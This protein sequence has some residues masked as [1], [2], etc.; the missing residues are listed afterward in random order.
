MKL[1][2]TTRW[3]AALGLVGGMSFTVPAMADEALEPGTDATE[4]TAVETTALELG[5]V[6]TLD[7]EEPTNPVEPVDPEPEP[8][9]EPEPDPTNPVDPEPEPSP[10]PTRPVAP[11]EPSEPVVPGPVT[12]PANPAL[13]PAEEATTLTALKSSLSVLDDTA[14]APVE[15]VVAQ[16]KPLPETGANVG[17]LAGIGA[18][19]LAGG[20]AMVA[21]TRK[22][23]K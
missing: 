9:P 15:T 19:L 16:S 22:T 8:E 17:A 21:A 4:P 12:D 13:G 2:K 3:A 10:E 23:H 7:E 20:G 18:V 1:I 6:V 14:T 11:V 5:E